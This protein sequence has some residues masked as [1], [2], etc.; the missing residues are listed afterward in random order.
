[1]NAVD[2]LIQVNTLMTR[3]GIALHQITREYM[4][5]NFSSPEVERLRTFARAAQSRA[6]FL[7][8]QIG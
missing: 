5:G 2:I 8:A 7:M 4:E 6:R 3:R 1:M